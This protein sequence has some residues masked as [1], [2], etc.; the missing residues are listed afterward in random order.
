[1]PSR[2]TDIW[3]V[4]LVIV[5][6]PLVLAAP[7]AAGAHE[8]EPT[9]R[10][11]HAPTRN[12]RRSPVSDGGEVPYR[13]KAAQLAGKAARSRHPDARR[14]THTQRERRHLTRARR[15]PHNTR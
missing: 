14:A 2:D 1:M 3:A 10:S 5:R 12:P 9:A 8:S 11:R 6:A 7:L 4:T 15:T 13:P